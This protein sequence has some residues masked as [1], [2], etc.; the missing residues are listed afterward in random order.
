MVILAKL[1]AKSCQNPS[2]LFA[3]IDILSNPDPE[4]HIEAQETGLPKI[5]LGKTT[6]TTTKLADR[7]QF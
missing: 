4:S 6:T 2:C 5:I 3:D 7:L 1:T